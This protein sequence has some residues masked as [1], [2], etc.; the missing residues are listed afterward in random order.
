V[1]D[2]AASQTVNAAADF[3]LTWNPF[4]GASGFDAIMVQAVNGLSN[5]VS[6][7]SLPYTATSS[8]L[9]AGT[10]QSGQSY[11]VQLKFR[12]SMAVDNML[13]LGATGSERFD[14]ATLFNLST[15][16]GTAPILL[17]VLNINNAA[18]LQLV[19]TGQIGLRYAIDASTNLE[20]GSWLPLVT[21]STVSG[22]FTFT[23]SQS[24]KFPAR[25]YRGRSVD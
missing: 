16:G 6:D 17:S 15:A 5:V 23:D 8:V 14:S 20:S 25:F 1:T 2:W 3:A 13:Y 4:T 11:K 18:G 9:P 24:S 10:F 19:L 12:H 7:V 21:N 22:Q